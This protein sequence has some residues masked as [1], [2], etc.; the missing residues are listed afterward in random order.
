MQTTKPA[1]ADTTN[2]DGDMVPGT[3]GFDIYL[4]TLGATRDAL[5][6]PKPPKGTK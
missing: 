5:R 6:A 1:P 3:I 4:A 2:Q